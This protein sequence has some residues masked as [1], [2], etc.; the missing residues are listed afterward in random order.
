MPSLFDPYDLGP[1]HL[2]NRIVMAPMTRTRT[3]VGD[4]PNELMTKYYGQRASAGLIVSEAT[5][6]SPHTKGYAWTPRIYT[7]QQIEGWRR[8]T[9]EVHRNGGKIFQQLRHVG[10]M[11]H[12]S[13][14]PNGEAPWGVT[15]EQAIG[16]QIFAHN[17]DGK[18]TYAQASPPRQISTEEITGVVKE[19]AQAAKNAKL[20]G[21]DGVEVHAANGYLLEQF[22]SSILNRRTDDYSGRT[23]ETRTRL[24]LEVIDA[25][26]R[27]MGTGRVG[28]RLSPRGIYNSMP[29]DP[30]GD[31]TFLF[32][33]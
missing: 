24:V 5:D 25:V 27:E 7:S 8:V 13:L 17:A 12:I 32:V 19:F 29:D 16:S 23:V 14:L 10:R 2:K 22:M 9:D 30:H 15:N 3:S 18:L 31:E 28:V 6:I 33:L 21:F 20:A 4:L 26:T 1:I 11:A